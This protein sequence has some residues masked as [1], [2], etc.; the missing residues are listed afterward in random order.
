MDAGYFD[1]TVTGQWNADW[2]TAMSSSAKVF[3]FLFP[4]WGI[5]TQMVPNWDGEEGAWAVTNAP[6]PYNWGG[7]YLVAATGTDNPT[8]VKEI[9]MAL[10]GNQDNLTKVAK[11]YTEFTNA[12][13]VM[14]AAA[15]GTEFNSAFLGGQNPYGY[16]ADSLSSI[17][18]AP[19]SSYDQGCVELIQNAFGDYLQGQI[20]Y[21]T[22]KANFETAIK[23]RYP[24][25]TEIQWP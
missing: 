14:D 1:P 9:I 3:A 13:T 19:L 10:T 8:H 23:E 21:D 24:E 4:A 25:I 11:E 6:L 15:N 20:D 5:D 7:T 16:F 18:M 22:A 2:F 17:K 12:Q